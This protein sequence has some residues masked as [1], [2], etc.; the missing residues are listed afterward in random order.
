M[1]NNIH[2]NTKFTRTNSSNKISNV[3]NTM[4]T[5]N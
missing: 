1:L 5:I 2:V 3:Y 4:L